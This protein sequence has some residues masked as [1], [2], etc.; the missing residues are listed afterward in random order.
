MSA[1]ECTMCGACCNNLGEN[2]AVLLLKEDISAIATIE[3]I[4]EEEVTSKYCDVSPQFSAIAGKTILQLK[5][6]NGG[7]CIFLDT[8]N[9]C[10]IH[11]YKPNQCRIGPER[12]MPHTMK[13][14]YEC[15][16]GVDISKTEDQTEKF[17]SL[18]MEM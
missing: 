10:S 11:E 5:S 9:K 4:T 7:R 18:L 2:Q 14:D 6:C 15:M 13:N 17:F 16:A 12:F 1:F 8:H 3:N